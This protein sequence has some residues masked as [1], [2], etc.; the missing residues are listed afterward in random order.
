MALVGGVTT[1]HDA[2]HMREPQWWVILSGV[3]MN[4]HIF[5]WYFF[6]SNQRNFRRSKLLNIGLIALPPAF[7]PYYVIRSRTSGQRLL[8]IAKLIGYTVLLFVTAAVGG[9]IASAVG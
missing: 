4:A 8:G 1:F 5:A 2:H 9:A 6:D 3:L 7:V